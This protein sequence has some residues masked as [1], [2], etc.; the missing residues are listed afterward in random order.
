MN[1]QLFLDL[2]TQAIKNTLYGLMING[3]K[4]KKIGNS[5]Y[6]MTRFL[7]QEFTFYLNDLTHQVQNSD[8]TIY[9]D[10]IP[11]DSKAESEFPQ[12]CESS[13]QVKFYFKLPN[14]FPIPTPIG[15]YN[16]D[17][18]LIL[19]DEK[20]I[21]FV[22]ETKD[23]GTYPIIDLRKLRIDEQLKIKCGYAHFREIA[24]VK[25]AVV[26]KVSDLTNK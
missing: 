7:S 4:Y 17:W 10:Y 18:A 20:E 22:A 3:I 8:K 15:T 21:Y 26:Q 9:Q 1:P 25:Y 23:T 16:P 2:A 11:L 13:E 19:E 5:T 24:P 12:D 14:W 6:K